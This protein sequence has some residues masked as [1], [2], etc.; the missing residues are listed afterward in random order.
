MNHN[1]GSEYDEAIS[2]LAS[3]R[4]YISYNQNNIF[5]RDLAIVSLLPSFLL[6]PIYSHPFLFFLSFLVPSLF[7]D[8]SWFY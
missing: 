3:I 5:L 2:I 1:A 4:I 7:S 6:M 8:C